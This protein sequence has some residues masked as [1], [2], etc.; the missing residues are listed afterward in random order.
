MTQTG[1]SGTQVGHA[2]PE[3]VEGD[4]SSWKALMSRVIAWPVLASPASMRLRCTVVGSALRCWASLLLISVRI[5]AGSASRLV[6]WSQT[7]VSR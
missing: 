2:A 3:L 6:M 7:T 5:R 4:H 1:L